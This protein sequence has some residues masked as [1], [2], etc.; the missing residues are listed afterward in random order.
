MS[1]SCA[2]SQILIV[3]Y[4]VNPGGKPAFWGRNLK[5]LYTL[6]IPP[7]IISDSSA[8]ISFYRPKKILG[9]YTYLQTEKASSSPDMIFYGFFHCFI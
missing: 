4:S 9:F 8:K 6:R 7:E 1:F 3:C 5:L 2:D